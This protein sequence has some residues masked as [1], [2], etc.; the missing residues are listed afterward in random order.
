M[1]KSG[2][3]WRAVGGKRATSVRSGLFKQVSIIKHNQAHIQ[4]RQAMR[5]HNKPRET[6]QAIISQ[7]SQNKLSRHK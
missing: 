5:S 6:K 1:G 4:I 2:L 3:K 7:T